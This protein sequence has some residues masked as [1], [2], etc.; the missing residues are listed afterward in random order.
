MPRDY[1]RKCYRNY[2]ELKLE[3]AADK[4]S[5]HQASREFSIPYVTLHNKYSGKHGGKPG[6]SIVF[7]EIEELAIIN[8]LLTCCDWAF[9]LSSVTTVLMC[10]S[11]SGILLP[12]YIIYKSAGIYD[13]WKEGGL[14]GEPWC[15]DPRCSRDFR[16]NRTKHGWIDSA[17]FND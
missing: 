16:Y 7:S 15:T 6:K 1:T 14:K 5:L 17:T 9:P 13:T 12:P 8:G 11:A 4:M 2:T 10:D 3:E